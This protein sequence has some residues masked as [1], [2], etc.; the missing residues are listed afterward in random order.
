MT[1]TAAPAPAPP[2]VHHAHVELDTASTVQLT[3]T[4][5]EIF[6]PLHEKIVWDYHEKGEI[7]DL[8][9]FGNWAKV[10]RN[11]CR[12]GLNMSACISQ[13]DN[14]LVPTNPPD[15]IDIHHGFV[16]AK[17]IIDLRNELASAPPHGHLGQGTSRAFR[18]RYFSCADKW[19][20][21]TIFSQTSRPQR[22]RPHRHPAPHLRRVPIPRAVQ[23][24]PHRHR[25]R[26][27]IA[28]QVARRHRRPAPHLRRVPILRAVQARPH[29]QRR[30]APLAVRVRRRQRHLRVRPP[31]QARL[32]L[33]LHATSTC[34]PL[35]ERWL[36]SAS[37]VA[38]ESRAHLLRTDSRSRT[39]CNSC[40]RCSPSV[41]VYPR[42]TLALWRSV[43]PER[44]IL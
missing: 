20:F 31:M 41:E 14:Q 28:I 9:G 8:Q 17:D 11:Y 32:R 24:R 16:I 13:I 29:R 44:T 6:H 1:D 4:Q 12:T 19:A 37:S 23:A 30:R 7:H 21:S 25:R 42:I 22:Q 36:G 3:G 38:S 35:V 2:I 5:V 43:N 18:K 26:A 40:V 33:D 34:R 15:A 39:T 27:P 10:F